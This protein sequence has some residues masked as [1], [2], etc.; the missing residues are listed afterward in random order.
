MHELARVHPRYGYRFIA[1]KLKDE[2]RRV[3][4]KRVHRLWRQEGLK[5]PK[6]QVKKRR[7]GSSVNGIVRKRAEYKDHVWSYDFVK[8]QTADGRP[9]K[10]LGV[11]DEFTRECLSLE[12]ARSIK[13]RDV[14]ATLAY[15]FEV[16]GVPGF[17]RSDNGPE[18]VAHEVKWFLARQ[19]VNT[20]FIEPGSPWE[21]A[22]I[23]SFNSRFRDEVLN[24][25]LFMG[26]EEAKVV[27]EDHRLDYNHRRPHSSLG[28]VAPARFAASL[29]QASAVERA[30]LALPAS[31]DQANHPQT[32]IAPGP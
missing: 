3:N 13:A 18:F 22:Y 26:L 9:F 12:V 19:G 5:V 7:L 32:L 24:R 8:D 25:E 27:V 29:G 31:P 28:Y 20:L 14:T 10:V 15:L 11:V 30:A 21:N 6:K 2:G 4:I 1:A 23:E 17:I 16:R